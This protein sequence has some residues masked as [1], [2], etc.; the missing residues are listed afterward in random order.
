MTI[1][2]FSLV[3]LGFVLMNLLGGCATNSGG[4]D[5]WIPLFNG[6]DLTGWTPK[7]AGY[8]LG[9]NYGNTFRV[10]DGILKVAY[11]QYDKFDGKFGHLFYSEVSHFLG[12]DFR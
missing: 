12:D 6:K 3:I 7:I 9:E 5:G 4:T 10:E 1:R 11:D 8:E 2:Q